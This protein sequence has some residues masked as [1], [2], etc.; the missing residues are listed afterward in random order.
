M[1]TR[2]LQER[3]NKD[4]EDT[5]DRLVRSGKV[6]VSTRIAKA[7]LIEYETTF[8]NGELYTT[9]VRNVGAGVKELYLKRFGG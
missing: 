2:Q 6:R 7:V 8:Y 9:H 1:T 3:L 5:V 4:I